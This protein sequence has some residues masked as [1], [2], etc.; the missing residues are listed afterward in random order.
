ML[1]Q[2]LH[3]KQQLKH[4]LLNMLITN[5]CICSLKLYKGWLWKTDMKKNTKR[6]NMGIQTVLLCLTLHMKQK[7][8][9]FPDWWLSFCNFSET[10]GKLFCSLCHLN[11][12]FLH[13]QMSD[14]MQSTG[15]SWTSTEHSPLSRALKDDCPHGSSPPFSTTATFSAGPQQSTQ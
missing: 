3:F 4:N 2:I 10:K 15:H 12:P 8:S 13:I 6:I 7:K 9:I 14:F 1:T 11:R 5:Q